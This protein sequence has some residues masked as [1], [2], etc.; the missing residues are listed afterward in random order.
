MTFYE[1]LSS[2]P[3]RIGSRSVEN[4]NPF[5]AENNL[6]VTSSIYD[7]NPT[8]DFSHDADSSRLQV[9]HLSPFAF[10]LSMYRS[11][12]LVLS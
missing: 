5:M 6:Q 11:I 9:E 1:V 12:V 4:A 8:L 7:V 3:T 2:V 10:T